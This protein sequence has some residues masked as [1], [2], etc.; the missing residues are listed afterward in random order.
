MREI[1]SDSSL[2]VLGS[3][4]DRPEEPLSTKYLDKLHSLY[5]PYQW[6]E[7]IV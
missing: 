4:S 1:L 6:Q 2:G 7:A 3:H 5:F